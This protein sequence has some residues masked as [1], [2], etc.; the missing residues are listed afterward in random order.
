M[1]E[2]VDY[3][4]NPD[5]QAAIKEYQETGKKSAYNKIGKSFI[6]LANKLAESATFNRYPDH[7]KENM[8]GDAIFTMIRKLD[9]YDYKQ[10]KNP[11]AYFTSVSFQ[12]FRQHIKKYYTDIERNVS[13]E[14]YMNNS[15]MV[16]VD[17]KYRD[18][19]DNNKVR[20]N[21]IK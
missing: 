9:K 11:F 2:K 19:I 7:I 8:V 21:N 13:L 20:T 14:T 17:E 5:M 3:I 10:Y 15:S 6:Q 16:A 4:S 18:K 1:V 12:I